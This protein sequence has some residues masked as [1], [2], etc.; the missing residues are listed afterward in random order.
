ML[1]YNECVVTDLL[2]IS[3]LI[4]E[5]RIKTQ[6]SKSKQLPRPHRDARCLAVT[7]VLPRN[8]TPEQPLWSNT[9]S[10]LRSMR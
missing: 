9:E 2:D 1:I 5:S 8:G 10:M 7:G 4:I 6:N 3:D